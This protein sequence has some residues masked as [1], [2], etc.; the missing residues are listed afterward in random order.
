MTGGEP[1][2]PLATR[3]WPMRIA[4]LGDPTVLEARARSLRT[5][6]RIAVCTAPSDVRAAK[7]GVLQVLPVEA[8]RPVVP[9]RLDAANARYVLELIRHGVELC[10][11]GACADPYGHQEIAMALLFAHGR[12][13]SRGGDI[14]YGSE[15]WRLLNIM[16]QKEQENGGV[17]DGVTNLLDA[18]T[19]LVVDQPREGRASFTRPANVKP[20]YYELWAQATGEGRWSAAAAAG[21]M[22]LVMWL[23]IW[24]WSLLMASMMVFG[25][26]I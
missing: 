5:T 7:A 17:V 18:Q 16:W 8:A 19:S 21:W 14:D 13:G 20:A 11:G 6:V 22:K 23:V 4:L 26:P 1:T 25:P 24:L 3:A 15:A 12:W 9:G 10:S 2:L